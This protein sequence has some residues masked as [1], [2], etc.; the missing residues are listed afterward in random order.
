MISK[1]C[2]SFKLPSFHNSKKDIRA[3]TLDEKVGE[4][5]L[6][7]DDLFGS[8]NDGSGELAEYVTY[9]HTFPYGLLCYA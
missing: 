5:S 3:K 1:K 6:D 7:F 9:M 2:V 8:E 4:K